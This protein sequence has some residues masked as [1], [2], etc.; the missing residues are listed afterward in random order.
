[1]LDGREAFYGGAAGGGKSDALLMAALQYVHVPRYSALLLRRTYADLSLPG[2]LMDRADEWLRGKAHWNDQTK[3]WTFPSGASVNFGYCETPKDRFRYQGSEY[4]F[5]GFDELTQFQ[6]IVYTYLFSRLRRLASSD[7]PIRM[8]AGSNP[9]GEGHTWVK[10]RFLVEGQSKGRTFVPAR[11][12]DNP[13]LDRE[14]YEQ[15]LSELDPTT[16][17]QLLRGDWEIRDKGRMFDRS[18]FEIVPVA[19][20]D[21]RRVRYWDLAA[22]EAKD[23][24]DPDWTAGAKVSRSRAGVYYIEDVRRTRSTP[25]GVEALV[26][27]TAQLD[28]IGVDTWME[29]EPGSAGVNTIDHYRRRVLDGFTFRG[30]K[31]TGNKEMRAMPASSQAEAGNVKL[32]SGAWIGDFLD[33]LELFPHGQHDDQVDAFTGAMARLATKG[34]GAWEGVQIPIVAP[35][36]PLRF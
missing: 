34:S 3:T 8:R 30:W 6:E 1:M 20:V 23:G 33:E 16:R 25:A 4:Q 36:T 15:S 28:G 24:K 7:V 17:M 18:W 35:T 21:A 11:L 22:T 5:I 32:V 26:K 10:Q 14:E 27:Q 31:E 13:S 19:P 12:E 29:Q 9:G 2:A